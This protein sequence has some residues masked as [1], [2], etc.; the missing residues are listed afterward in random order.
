MK[1]RDLVV[2]VLIAFTVL[3]EFR[4]T[5]AADSVESMVGSWAFELPD[6]GPAW[7]QIQKTD[8]AYSGSL[9]WS[10]G[11]AKPVSQLRVRGNSLV[12][13]QKIRWQPNGADEE[14]RVIN[15]PMIATLVESQLRLQAV[16]SPVD[17]TAEERVVLLGKRLPPLP[18]RPDLTRIRFGAPISL[19]N[20]QD[21]T[22]WRLSNPQKKKNGWRVENGA[23]VN[24]TPKTDFSAYGAYGNLRTDREFEDF[25]LTIEY[26][27]AAGGNSGVYLRGMYEAQVVDRDSKMQGINGPGA[28]FGRIAPSKNAGKPGG[29]W[30]RYELTLVDRHITVVLNGEKVIDNQP[31]IGCTGGGLSADD[32]KPGPVFLQG[33][34]TSVQYRNIV[35]RPVV[36]SP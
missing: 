16:Q 15:E 22:G 26:N 11:S 31:I 30:N 28:I 33:D 5:T 12:F 8:G 18:S 20:G 3:W 17:T 34:H 35:L 29:Q 19:F 24:E 10:V 32:T 9:L 7:L 2:Y 25:Q 13:Q 1:L 36:P 27:V 21:L 6:G 14:T 23:L 4:V